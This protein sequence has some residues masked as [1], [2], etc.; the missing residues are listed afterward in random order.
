MTFC[1]PGVFKIIEREIF[2]LNRS[3]IIFVFYYM[4]ILV[5]LVEKHDHGFVGGTDIRQSLIHHLNLFFKGR[6]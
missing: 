6:M 1:H 2:F 4:R 3:K 5:D